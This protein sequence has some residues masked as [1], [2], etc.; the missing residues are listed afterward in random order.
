[1][2]AAHFPEWILCGLSQNGFCAP[3]HTP[4]SWN[5][6]CCLIHHG[7]CTANVQLCSVHPSST[8]LL[9]MSYAHSVQCVPSLPHLAAAAVSSSC[10]P[11]TLGHCH[12][13]EK[14]DCHCTLKHCPS[15]PFVTR[16]RNC[17]PFLSP[18]HYF[19]WNDINMIFF[20]FCRIFLRWR[21]TL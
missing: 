17:N 15:L 8:L 10:L 2:A 13:W 14:L 18:Q 20:Y 16:N 9:L 11:V 21:I 6:V 3:S 5:L 1:M 7:Y 12:G 4:W 19:F